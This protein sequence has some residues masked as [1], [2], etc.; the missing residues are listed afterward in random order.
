MRYADGQA[1]RVGDNVDCAGRSG[2]V[3]CCISDGVYS[4]KHREADWSYLERGVLIDFPATMGLVHIDAAEDDEDLRLVRR[5]AS[6][7]AGS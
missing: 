1:I 3:V 6:S 7:P 4:E 2:I 5:A